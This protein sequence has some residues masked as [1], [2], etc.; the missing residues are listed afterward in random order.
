MKRTHKPYE[1][2]VAR[3]WAKKRNVA[4]WRIRGM[5]AQARNMNIDK[6]LTFEEISAF[7]EVTAKLKTVISGWKKHNEASKRD[8]LLNK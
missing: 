3:D 4:I 8:F 7:Y 6:V 2:T 5:E 1:N